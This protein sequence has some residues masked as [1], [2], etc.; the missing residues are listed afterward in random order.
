ML[1]MPQLLQKMPKENKKSIAEDI[2]LVFQIIIFVIALPMS[3]LMMVFDGECMGGNFC[4]KLPGFMSFIGALL[5]VFSFSQFTIVKTPKGKRIKSI[6]KSI[7]AALIIY[8]I[9][10]I[11]FFI[12]HGVQ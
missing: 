2:L 10:V 4:D 7:A 6:A 1:K 3:L 9:R 8:L 5:M 12:T 11:I